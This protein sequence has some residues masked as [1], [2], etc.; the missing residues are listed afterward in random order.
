MGG[1]PYIWER[2]DRVARWVLWTRAV[3]LY[4]RARSTQLG[5]STTDRCGAGL[6]SSVRCLGEGGENAVARDG[7]GC[8]W[9]EAYAGLELGAGRGALQ[10]RCGVLRPCDL[11]RPCH[12]HS[13]GRTTRFA[14]LCM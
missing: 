5:A 1:K 14:L 8:G 12:P 11:S 3:R 9:S 7:S 2:G 10:G 4:S 6:H 13:G